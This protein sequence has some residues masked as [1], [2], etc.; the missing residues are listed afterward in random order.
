MTQTHTYLLL[1]FFC[2]S[3]AM[4]NAEQDFLKAFEKSDTPR[5]RELVTGVNPKILA[6]ALD[7]AMKKCDVTSCRFIIN[8]SSLTG[9][10]RVNGH[11]LL[12]SALFYKNANALG[13]LLEKPLIEV[14]FKDAHG[15]TLLEMIASSGFAAALKTVLAK[16]VY[17]PDE[18]KNALVAAVLNNQNEAVS[19]LLQFQVCPNTGYAHNK[20]PLHW[21]VEK[22]NV[23]AVEILLE[24]NADAKAPDAF[25]RTPLYIAA[26]QRK[27]HQATAHLLVSNGASVET[28]Y[29]Y[30]Q[31]I[32]DRDC[33]TNLENWFPNDTASITHVRH[34][35][36]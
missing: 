34:G 32:H 14:H 17:G 7:T 20:T 16:N 1:F 30:A 22:N 9:N 35:K 10:E 2:S 36:K 23:Q 31:N 4:E 26:R 33:I 13:L 15:V 25:G 12:A 5:M 11:R 3:I 19:I 6:G 29:E 28:T 18:C 24:K 21:A 27:A 8:E